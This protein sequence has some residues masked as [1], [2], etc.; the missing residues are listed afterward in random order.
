[1]LLSSSAVT[2]RTSG[3]SACNYPG[4]PCHKPRWRFWDR[5]CCIMS[6]SSRTRWYLRWR[7]AVCF[8]LL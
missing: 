3:L 8:V 4:P 5:S 6:S 7:P 2:I 1:M